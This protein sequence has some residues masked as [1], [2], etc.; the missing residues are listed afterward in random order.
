MRYGDKTVIATIDIRSKKFHEYH[1]CVL[2]VLTVNAYQK[3]AKIAHRQV[4]V[5]IVVGN[6]VAAGILLT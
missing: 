5:Q 4:S 1:I 6:S 3:I 2:H